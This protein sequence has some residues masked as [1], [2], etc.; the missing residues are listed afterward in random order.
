MDKC[1]VFEQARRYAMALRYGYPE[2]A[3]EFK[4]NTKELAL[5]EIT[6]CLEQCKKE[7]WPYPTCC[8]VAFLKCGEDLILGEVTDDYE[9]IVQ[10][11]HG[12]LTA[13]DGIRYAPFTDFEGEDEFIYFADG[14]RVNVCVTVSNFTVEVKASPVNEKTVKREVITDCDAQY[15]WHD[16]STASYNYLGPHEQWSV[17]A[18]CDGCREFFTECLTCDADLPVLT[19]VETV[20]EI[21]GFDGESDSLN[22]ASS[23]ITADL[24]TAHND[25]FDDCG[26]PVVNLEQTEVYRYSIE[27]T[28][29]F[30]EHIV[31]NHP[32]SELSGWSAKAGL[33]YWVGGI[34]YNTADYEVTFPLNLSEVH[35][36]TLGQE[37]L[38][39]ANLTYADIQ[40]ISTWAITEQEIKEFIENQG[41]TVGQVEITRQFNDFKI[42]VKGTNAPLGR[43]IMQSSAGAELFSFEKE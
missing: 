27:D 1:K 2:V 33:K 12:Q 10:P 24:Q 21:V 8:S 23:L 32:G 18:I 31:L 38:L 37:N 4:S 13:S 22:K 25:R 41:Y 17:E 6:G 16:G 3:S 7:E 42:R 19:G 14:Q 36:M 29:P 35:L 20:T 39:G 26:E 28:P 34:C 9:V 15:L 5:A 30:V 40:S 11:N 43:V